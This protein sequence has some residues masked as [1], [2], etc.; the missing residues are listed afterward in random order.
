MLTGMTG[1]IFNTSC[2]RLYGPTPKAVLFW[3]GTLIIDATGFCAA[4]ASASVSPSAAGFAAG[5]VVGL[6]CESS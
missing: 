6:V 4:F 5:A 2:V 1:W 3:S